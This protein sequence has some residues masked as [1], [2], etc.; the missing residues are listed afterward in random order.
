MTKRCMRWWVS[1]PTL[2]FVNYFKIVRFRSS[3]DPWVVPLAIRGWYCSA[4]ECR[5][6]GASRAKA[7]T[8][9]LRNLT[10]IQMAMKLTLSEF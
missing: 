9:D 5:D 1:S 2:M 4:K 8:A 6:L 3:R 7:Y 10:S